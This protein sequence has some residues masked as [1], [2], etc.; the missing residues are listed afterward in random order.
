MKS[1]PN[2][3]PESA[4]ARK[5]ECKNDEE[6]TSDLV[7]HVIE[8]PEVL[9]RVLDEPRVQSI[10]LQKF[11]GPV[12]PPS[13]L[14]EYESLVP[15][16]ADRLVKLTEKEQ[17]HRHQQDE[18]FLK[19][20]FSLSARGQWMAFVIVLVIIA[21]AIFFGSQGETTLAAILVGIDMV[22]ICSVFIAGK[23]IG[24]KDKPDDENEN[25]K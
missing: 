3:A 10:V 7:E 17:A 21:T 24:S 22:A 5:A 14:R 20:N 12:P 4:V 25:G 23:F 13:L 16:L 6:S 9:T 11:Q 2:K 8:N 1:K 15:G 18:K 19:G